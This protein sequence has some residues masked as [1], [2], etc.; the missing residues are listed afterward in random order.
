MWNKERTREMISKIINKYGKEIGIE[1]S[2]SVLGLD[3]HLDKLVANMMG[4]DLEVIKFA[5]QWRLIIERAAITEGFD[6]IKELL[7]SE[8]NKEIFQAEDKSLNEI[9][10]IEMITEVEEESLKTLELESRYK[11]EQQDMED[12]RVTKDINKK[13]ENKEKNTNNNQRLKGMLVDSYEKVSLDK[14]IWAPK[15]ERC[16]NRRNIQARVLA[17]NVL[18]DNAKHRERSLRWTLRDNTHIKKI[19]EIFENSNL[20]CLILFDCEKGYREAKKKLENPKEDYEKLRLFSREEPRDQEFDIKRP[21][22][23]KPDYEEIQ[24]KKTKDTKQK[25]ENENRRGKKA[26][27]ELEEVYEKR[28]SL[29]RQ[30]LT[31][32]E[33]AKQVFENK[34]KENKSEEEKRAQME[35]EENFEWRKKDSL[36]EASKREISIKTERNKEKQIVNKIEPREDIRHITV[37]DLPNWTRRTQVFEAVRYFGRVEHIEIV[38]ETYNKTKAQVEFAVGT[39]DIGVFEETWCIPFMR[40]FLVRVTPGTNNYEKLKRRNE[41]STRLL[42]LP[43]NTNEVLLWRQVRHTGAK[44]LHIFKNNN[45]NNMRSATIYF[46]NRRD[47]LESFKYV[48]YYYNNKLK[49][50]SWKRNGIK[51][52]SDNEIQEEEPNRLQS[53]G[54]EKIEYERNTIEEILELNIGREE[55]MLIEDSDEEISNNSCKK[56][57]PKKVKRTSKGKVREERQSVEKIENKKKE[58]IRELLENVLALIEKENISTAEETETWDQKIPSRS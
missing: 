40:D 36:I 11:E 42:D 19:S 16:E 44:S 15:A 5:R 39:C 9:R 49:W 28:K 4:L 52:N 56:Q 57:R 35:F 54:K 31:L 17:I 7:E 50:A 45:S 43:K 53:R 47:L 26:Q 58:S 14:S 55:T 10:E 2:N 25:K 34:E 29:T 22:D 37:W 1:G 13:E 21:E 8:E 30:D 3:E 12:I 48:V 51:D 46:A 20:W 18:G 27:I 32:R 24:N 23:S 33:K 6:K 41:F 38:R